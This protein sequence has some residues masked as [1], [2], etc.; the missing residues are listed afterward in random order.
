MT[1]RD[2]VCRSSRPYAALLTKYWASNV[3]IKYKRAIYE[4]IFREI[5]F[6]AVYFA[7]NLD[8][9]YV[10]YFRVIVFIRGRRCFYRG[11]RWH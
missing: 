11:R 1:N 5:L 7:R 10:R 9:L 4:Q 8:L 2:R 3:G 6:P